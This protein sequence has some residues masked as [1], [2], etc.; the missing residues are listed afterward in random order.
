MMARRTSRS[1]LS[2]SGLPRSVAVAVAAAAAAAASPAAAAEPPPVAPNVLFIA[3]DDLRPEHG[4][5]GGQALTPNIDAFA[6][7]ALAFPRNYVQIGVCSP[8]RTSLLTGRYPDTTHITDLWHYFRDVGCNVTT[9]PQAFK[10]AGY[11]VAGGGKIFHPGHASGAGDYPGGGGCPGCNGYNDPPSWDAYFLPPASA[12][13]PWNATDAFSSLPLPD[14]VTDAAH[15]DG[16]T[17]GWAAGW[18]AQHAA[19][20]PGTPFF[21][22]PG[23][24]KPHLPF[25]APQRFFDLYANYT[26]LAADDDPA[27]DEAPLSWTGWSELVSYADIAAIVKADNISLAAPSNAMPAAKALELRRAYF[28]A[29]SFNDALVGQVLAALTASGFAGNTTVV[30]WGDH[31]WQLGD[32][33]DWAKHTNFESVTRAPLLIRS[34]AHPAAAG[35][36]SPAFT[37]HIDLFPTL[38]DLTG[39]DF[40]GADGLQ[41]ESL[42]PLLVD[43]TRPA[44]PTRGAV[45]YSQYPRKMVSCGGGEPDCGY[46]KAMGYTLRTAEWRY[47]EWVP[48]DNVTYTPNFHPSG[49]NATQVELYFHGTDGGGNWTLFESAARGNVASDPAYA[50]V[51]AHL[52]QLLHC[53]PGLLH[54][55]TP[56]PEPPRGMR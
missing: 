33:G 20:A 9:L 27:A 22:A 14:N 4:A 54:P 28:A 41:G 50:T 35:A 25:I 23:F 11:A 10:R 18:L 15:P 48:Y 37:Q 38:V 3:V 34:P 43:P 17:A 47:T 32:H 56:C 29:V 2:R 8:S 46:P 49:A 30:L 19:T 44:L 40:P 6:R 51:V 24:L 1:G 16:Q 42:V 53:G 5:F 39:I 7:T 52:S 21:L 45:A 26:A 13:Y 31:G 12:V 36:A 55:E